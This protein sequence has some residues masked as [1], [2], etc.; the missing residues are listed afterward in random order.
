MR[1]TI[2][3]LPHVN[4]GCNLAATGFLLA[5]FWAIRKGLVATHRRL[6]LAAF[7]CS[8]LFLVFYL[9]YHFEVGSVRFQ[10]TGA[11]RAIYLT[12]LIS[13][14]LL[15]ALVPF[16][17]LVTLW[18]GLRRRFEAHQRIARWTFPI[19]LYVSVTGVAIYWMLYRLDF[20]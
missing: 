15:A 10:G 5:G 13:H 3:L 14:S 2:E 1:E 17:A 4:A 19:W 18:R 6:M 12:V 7:A 8:V 11:L 20:S 16:L 9:T